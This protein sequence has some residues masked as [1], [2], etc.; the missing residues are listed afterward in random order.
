[1]RE[2]I[3]KIIPKRPVY[4]QITFTIFAFLVMVVLSYNFVNKIV[5]NDLVRNT[6]SILD[7]VDSQIQSDITEVKAALGS[8]AQTVRSM[9]LNREGKAKIINY[10]NEISGFFRSK[11]HTGLKIEGFYGYIE[12][13][14]DGP[15]FLNGLDMAM[16]ADFSPISRPWYLSSVVAGDSIAETPPYIDAVT[17]EIIITFS[18][19]IYDNED[20]YLGVVCIDVRLDH[21]RKKIVN[22][23]LT[24]DGYGFLVSNDLTLIAHPNPEFVGR[25]ITDIEIPL[26]SLVSDMLNGGKV[27]ETPLINWKGEKTIA[28]T[29]PLS[30]GWYLGLLAVKNLYYKNVKTMAITLSILGAVLASILIMVLVRVDAAKQKSDL[31]NRHKSAFL[32]NMSHEI[33]TPMNAI[34]G[35]I[36]IGKS[37]VDIERKDY[38]FM[39]IED[40][41]NHLLGVIND[42]LDMSKIEA[43]KFELSCA[44]FEFEKM[45]QR[46]VNVINFRID[47]KRQKFSVHIDSSIPR[48]LVGDDQRLAQVITNLLGNAIK[49]TPEKGSIT[50]TVRLADEENGV[51]TLQVGI[52]DTGIGISAEQ[53]A[54]LF[55]SFEQAESS[56]TRRYGGTGLGLAISKSIVEMMGGNIWVQSDI[57]RGSTF[58]FTVKLQRGKERKQIFLSPDVNLNNIRILAVDDDKDILTYFHDIMLEFGITC[59]TAASGE[60]ALVLIKQ[61][62][63]Y[64][65]YFVDWKMPGMNGIQLANKLKAQMSEN[66]V[67]IMISAAEWSTVAE[68]AKKAGVDKFL[69][70]PLFPSTVAE[71][72]SECM[73]T[74]KK[75]I[76]NVQ[77]DIAGLFAGRRVLLAEDV[78]INREIVQ[79]LLGPTQLEIYCA[80]N[81]LEAVSMFSKDPE[82]YEMIFMDVQMPEMDGYEATK[83]IRALDFPA[84]KTVPIIAMTANVFKEDIE[85]CLTAG[86]NGHVGKPL[87]FKEVL[88]KLNI[89][90][91]K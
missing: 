88:E 55:Q 33:R 30:N 81:G 21:V 49:F 66:S 59:D 41:S 84:A 38:C 80:E 8:F 28:F 69:S 89:Y 63:P 40:A 53:Q 26:S 60:E 56:T 72:I 37:A 57:G 74:N 58:A 67:V 70:K 52:S 13:Y 77:E 17:G 46:V 42:I 20:S 29:R 12:K 22:T 50:V 16:P 90:L 19:N 4:I 45:L 73:G 18:Q 85:R 36:T 82:K 48:T 9:L 35:M 54:K 11:E 47:E 65:I 27:S 15:V 86:M 75:K 39:K 31:E 1:M 87:D 2:L 24:K 25:K 10:T 78:E 5:L 34:I 43:N 7:F 14:P 23:A 44:E 3:K 71:I 64:H 6:E 32:A 83:R 68:E 79:T 61:N 51:C 62:G 91:R 76:E